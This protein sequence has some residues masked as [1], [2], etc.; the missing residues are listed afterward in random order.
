MKK[1]FPAFLMVAISTCV[2]AQQTLYI[3]PGTPIKTIDNVNIVLNNTSVVNHGKLQQQKGEGSILFEGND[4]ST[5]SGTGNTILDKVTIAKSNGTVVAAKN[6]LSIRSAIE[7]KSGMMDVTNAVVDLGT[8]GVLINEA[9][10]SHLFS[11]ASGYVKSTNL[12]NNPVNSN[13]GNLGFL[14]SSAA[15]LGKTT[16]KRGNEAAMIAGQSSSSRYYE[17]L[18]EN[19]SNLN[20][21][22]RLK[23]LD[24]EL[25]GL[26][27]STISFYRPS[28][29]RWIDVGMDEREMISNYVSKNKVNSLSKFTLFKGG[30]KVK[31]WPNPVHSYAQIT[32]ESLHTATAN[33]AIF[34]A[35]G[36]LIITK[37]KQLREGTN[38]FS[39]SVNEL[40]SGNYSLQA[41]WNNNIEV[42][43]LVKD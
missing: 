39:I 16:I 5:I 20:A 37:Q 14:I 34:D 26:K 6:N 32:I 35:N 33:L 9:E 7:F 19:N 30:E 40:A 24:A 17:I 29:N 18:P 8:E 22:I 23:Y 2:S 36:R 4:N 38:N 31:V 42:I 25:N 1:V 10:R 13:P 3:A 21:T 28:G 11:S 41:T 27:E 15:D 43:K 12:L